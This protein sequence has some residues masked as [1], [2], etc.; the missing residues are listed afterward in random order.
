[1]KTLIGFLL[2]SLAVCARAQTADPVVRLK[3]G[4]DYPVT[5]TFIADAAHADTR[6]N[7]IFQ[8][9]LEN[10]INAAFTQDTLPAAL[11]AGK[12]LPVNLHVSWH[13]T[14][15]VEHD[16]KLG[17]V[18]VLPEKFYDYYHEIWT[19]I[20][21]LGITAD[22]VFS[23][24]RD[25][26]QSSNR[27]FE[28]YSRFLDKPQVRRT[29][30]AEHARC[31]EG[32]FSWLVDS[33]RKTTPDYPYIVGRVDLDY[34]QNAGVLFLWHNGLF[35]L[36]GPNP[37]WESTFSKNF[38]ASLPESAV[39]EFYESSEGGGR[40]IITGFQVDAS[41]F[42]TIVT[43]GWGFMGKPAKR[44]GFSTRFLD[45][46]FDTASNPNLLIFSAEPTSR[47]LLQMI[48]DPATRT[49]VFMLR[50]RAPLTDDER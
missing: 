44:L 8:K 10:A 41:D 24:P 13:A 14:L 43:Q 40:D 49:V 46:S 5:L 15:K 37:A 39:V 22:M 33:D 20:Q 27:K 38:G 23:I 36:G 2:L 18:I 45:Y 11:N 21:S 19:K 50:L 29:V 1:M 48:C 16:P 6:Y 7:A 9:S 32:I 42:E 34:K 12:G 30:V 3:L 35:V 26:S 25:I 31:V 47:K 17:D 28:L 4:N